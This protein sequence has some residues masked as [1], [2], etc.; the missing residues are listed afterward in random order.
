MAHVGGKPLRIYTRRDHERGVGVAAFVQGDRRE[1]FLLPGSLR[2]RARRRRIERRLTGRTEHEPLEAPLAQAVRDHVAP[3][4]IRH[5]HPAPTRAALWLDR[6]G[7]LI[8]A[9]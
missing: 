8:P 9:L 7:K 4:R 5:R 1:S 3:K 2:P 6:P